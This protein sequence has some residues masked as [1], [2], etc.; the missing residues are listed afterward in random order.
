LIKLS[1]KIIKKLSNKTSGWDWWKII[2]RSAAIGGWI[3][4]FLYLL[5]CT[6]F[7]WKLL[8]ISLLGYLGSFNP[9]V[10]LAC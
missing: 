6:V 9:Y 2:T 1:Y 7:P 8:T 4:Q 10:K 5:L 3:N